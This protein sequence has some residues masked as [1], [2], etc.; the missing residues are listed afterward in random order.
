MSSSLTSVGGIP[1]STE[2][3]ATGDDVTPPALRIER[4]ASWGDIERPWGDW[5]AHVGK[6]AVKIGRN[7]FLD[8]NDL[9]VPISPMILVRSMVGKI[10]KSIISSAFNAL[11]LG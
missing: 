6:R 10:C 9:A 7:K 5:D 4:S 2:L 8:I 3:S 11:K 1:S